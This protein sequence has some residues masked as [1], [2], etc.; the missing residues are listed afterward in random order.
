[1]PNNTYNQ[2]LFKQFNISSMEEYEKLS[3]SFGRF[4]LSVQTVVDAVK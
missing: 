3:N 2:E 1:M 4:G